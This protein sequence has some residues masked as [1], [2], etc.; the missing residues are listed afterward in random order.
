M[1]SLCNC[2]K[3]QPVEG[4]PD[5][6]DEPLTGTDEGAIPDSSRGGMPPAGVA[7][8]L[9]GPSDAEP[10]ARMSENHR[11]SEDRSGGRC[12]IKQTRIVLL[13]WTTVIVMIGILPLD[14]FVGHSHWE[15]I[16]WIPNAED[17]NSPKYLL[18]IFSDII[19]NTVLFFP[20]GYLL[21][22]LLYYRTPSVQLIFP[23]ALAGALSLS[24][25]YYQVYCHYRF[26]GIIDV[27]CNLSGSFIGARYARVRNA[28]LD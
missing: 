20:F 16:K 14:N 28:L 27:I 21:S 1:F 2:L 8:T 13:I 10:E 18:D 24:I 4:L 9:L 22:R 5:A 3:N 7:A 17:L 12:Q 15:Y 23:V 19:G 11:A 25:E 6:N 26:P